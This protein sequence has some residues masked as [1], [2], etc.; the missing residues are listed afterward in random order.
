[1]A[2]NY[3]AKGLKRSALTVALG[4]CF[5]GGVQA[6][7]TS[8]NIFG[9]VS[10]GEGATVLV[11]N[12]S[13]LSRTITVSPNGQYNVSALPVGDYTVTASRGGQVIGTRTITVRA[14]AGADVSFG[15]TAT[16]DA[17]TVTASNVPVIDI[18][19]VDTRS[20]LTAQQLERLP[21]RRSAEAIALLAPGAISGAAGYF[22]G[23]VSF[24]G[25]GVSENSYY[26]NG[27]FTGEPLSNL[28]GFTLP[29]G[30]IEQ[31][32]TYLGGYS[33]KYGRS[34]GGVISQIG[35]RGSNEWVFGAQVALVPKSL[36]AEGADR[37]YPNLK[38]PAG[39]AYGSTT[40]PG[41]LY[42]RGGESYSWNETYSA[43]VG[44]PLLKDRLFLFASAEAYK[45][46]S[47][48]APV[49]GGVIST[50]GEVKDPKI[51]AKLDWNITDNHFLE[52]TYMGEKYDSSGD[53][54]SYDF[55]TGVEGAKLTTQST[56]ANQNSEYVIA[57][58]T[59]YLTDSLTLS[60]TFG[61]SR[62]NNV[63]TPNI[64]PGLA[65]IS[66]NTLQDP[67]L[68]GG[69]PR[70]NN[71]TAFQGVDARDYTDGLR[72]DLEWVVGDHTMTLGVDNIKF[73]AQN[74]GTAQ[75]ANRW[76]YGKVANPNTNLSAAL[77]VGAP[78]G[79]GYYVYDYK[80]FTSTSMS[81][82]QKAWYLEDRWQV[83]DNFLLS[84][85]LR[86]D[87]FTNANNFGTVY[88]DAKNQ[89]A[90]RVGASWDVF[91][92][93]S[94]KVFGNVGRYFLAMPNN[95]A[96]RGA[97]ASTFTREYF[98][99]TGINAN[100]EPTGLKAVGGTN[101]KPAPGPVSSNG[102]TGGQVDVLAF[103]PSDLKNMY[104]D[105]FILGFEKTLGD[106][107][108]IGAKMTH[109]SLKSSVDDICDPYTFMDVNGL[110]PY[111]IKD[112]K[113]LA[114]GAMGNVEIASCYMFNPGGTNT[115]SV[116]HVDPITGAQTGTRTD[117]VMSYKDWGFSDGLKRVYNGFD[118]YLEHPF[119]GKW[120]ARIDY[121][122]SKS[123]G[124]N[125][126]QV[127]SEFG[128]SN[129]SKTQD[130]DAWQIMAFSN[131]YLANDRRHQLKARG[132]YQI[133]P[134]W[135]V[136]GNLRIASG[137]PISCLGY[138]NPNGSLTQEGE[139]AGDPI[140]Y[141]PSYHT[142]FGKVVSPGSVRT[143]WT[144]TLDGGVT[145]RPEFLDKKL[146]L[147]MQVFNL[148]N[149]RK[150]LQQSV[151]SETAPYTVSNTYLLPQGFQT[152]RYVMFTASYDW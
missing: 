66:S 137:M 138:Y 91:G 52:M 131:G 110:T 149:N 104:Q 31:Q 11:T 59:G 27:Y 108:M 145:Y 125:E 1:M 135:S 134:E 41:T 49:A 101:G 81:L 33:A 92:D 89:W 8:G 57:K 107:W 40:Q 119:D 4:L 25:S 140:G 48:S 146:A 2:S 21:L 151:T 141:G 136:G 18:S 95:V 28:G 30:S 35:K 150:A 143:P 99:Y 112:G 126:G 45:S 26:V 6:Q 147:G 124:N 127:K 74:E 102:E 90:P 132:S 24:G 98:T 148:L 20:V 115:F 77:G 36:R 82:E 3:L 44:G 113:Y 50:H 93:S 15:G 65:L 37:Y 84:L 100:G 32:E 130:W 54:Y 78:G 128:Q 117:V 14:G 42:S 19:A 103:A 75:L 10:G 144:T 152:A 120:E 129:I 16:L 13:G 121:T 123:K 94:L 139:D 61:H 5:V 109:R 105:E 39:Y 64:I 46:H 116:A 17:V 142:C 80:Y 69:T 9:N 68:N 122:F 118:V 97:S 23:L 85:G 76:I 67:A 133:T 71:Q 114:K 87:Q 47:V 56:P 34:D 55:A 53:Q 62:F 51:Y 73:E 72:A 70:Y 63:Q 88:M 43:Y 7:S 38:L 22:G 58:Y 79:N 106:S 111:A 60:A 29:Y 86:N 83:T 96:I 12:N